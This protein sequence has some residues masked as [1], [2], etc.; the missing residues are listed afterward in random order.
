MLGWIC[1]HWNLLLVYEIKGAGKNN[2]PNGIIKNKIQNT[3]NSTCLPFGTQ[4]GAELLRS[5]ADDT[6]LGRS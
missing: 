6:D 2:I 4:A 3:H 5:H 1:V